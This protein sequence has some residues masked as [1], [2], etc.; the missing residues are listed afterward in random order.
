MQR[1]TLTLD[2]L[3]DLVTTDLIDE[4]V[5]LDNVASYG[6]PI[7]KNVARVQIQTEQPRHRDI[8]IIWYIGNNKWTYDVVTKYD[9]T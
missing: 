2:S 4:R 9:N 1:S 6:Y 5:V 8:T 3:Y 7:L